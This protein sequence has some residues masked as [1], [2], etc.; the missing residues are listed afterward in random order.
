MTKDDRAVV[1]ADR[2]ADTVPSNAGTLSLD[3]L[4]RRRLLGD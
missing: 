2:E 1:T 3:H 4:I